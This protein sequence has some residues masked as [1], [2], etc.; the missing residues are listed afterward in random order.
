MITK[1][2]AKEILLAA[3]SQ[4]G[5]FAEIFMEKS[6]SVAIKWDNANVEELV[7][8]TDQGAGLTVTDGEKTFFGAS[9]RVNMESMLDL[10]DRLAG[11]IK[12]ETIIRNIKFSQRNLKPFSQ[13]KIYPDT[14]AVAKKVELLRKADKAA[15]EYDPRIVQVTGI[16]RDK[17][18]NVLVANSESVFDTDCRVYPVLFIEAVAKTKELVQTGTGMLS[19]TNGFEMFR[20]NIPE[21]IGREAAR[22]AIFQLEAKPTPAGT[23]TVVIL[24]TAE[25]GVLLHEAV[26]H[27]LEADYIEKNFS[28]Y[29]G[30]IGQKVASELITV[31]DDRTIPNQRGTAK[32]DDE[33]YPCQR[34]VLIKDGILVGYLQN[35]KFAKKTDMSQTG[36]GRRESFRY[37]SIPRMGNTIMISGQTPTKKIVESLKDGIL[38]AKLGGAGQ[39]DPTSGDFVF[40]VDEAYLVK[41]SRREPIRGATLVGN[42]PKILEEIDLVGDDDLSFGGGTCGKGQYVPVAD[43]QPTIRIPKIVVGGLAEKED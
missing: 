43:G 31:V 22:S 40:S 1:E 24:S 20:E 4:G 11:R 36:H 6:D 19:G 29:A 2:E 16:Y 14:V 28:V 21:E 27:G 30:R 17:V 33:G 23:Y 39:V 5:D 35:R 41:D 34:T 32:I 15:R 18:Q 12:K 25:G 3:L 13:V 9:N 8:G 10:A 38:V 37:L 26:G 7:T 42:G